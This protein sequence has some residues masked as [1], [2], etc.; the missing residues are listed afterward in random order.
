VSALS[1]KR[2]AYLE[3]KAGA[4]KGDGERDGF[5]VA[6]KSALRK[7]VADNPLSGLKL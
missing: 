7:T 2:A 4:A 1:K 3:E 5:D 6:A